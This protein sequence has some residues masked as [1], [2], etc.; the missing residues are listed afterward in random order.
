MI[1]KTDLPRRT[2][3]WNAA[4]DRSCIGESTVLSRARSQPRLPPV[5]DAF[6][7]YFQSAQGLAGLFLRTQRLNP[8]ESPEK[9]H[10]SIVKACE[11][12]ERMQADV[13]ALSPDE[14]E[15]MKP[16]ERDLVAPRFGR[17]IACAEGLNQ[18]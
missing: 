3:P 14:M 18:K 5:E 8:N 12:L 6:L 15:R 7:S 1:R 17:R 16:A 9:R 4:G 13:A 2:P 11:E 10:E